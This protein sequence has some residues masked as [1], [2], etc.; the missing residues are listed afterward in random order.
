MSNMRV[1]PEYERKG[2]GRMMLEWGLEQAKVM[3]KRIL[4]LATPEG[5]G[6]YKKY[7]FRTE[8]EILMPL[9]KYGE[10]GMYVQ[11][12]MIWDGRSA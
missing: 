9:E 2:L 11:S 3:Q 1:L 7:E 8:E 10:E 12:A 4:L 6:L 5:R